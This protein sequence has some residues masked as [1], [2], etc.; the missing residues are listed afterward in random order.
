MAY[1]VSAD[2]IAPQ[3]GGFEPQRKNNFTLVIP[4]GGEILQQSLESFPIPTEENPALSIS[5]GNE[6]RKV[7]APAEYA[8]L[9]LVVKDFIDS[10]VMKQIMTWRRKVY[11]PNTGKIG[12]ARDYK[13]QGEVIMFGPDGNRARKWKL[14]GI[15]PSKVDPGGGNMSANENNMISVTFQVDK[16][17]EQ[18]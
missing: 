15:W 5:F 12:Y 2:H 1:R 18:F 7:A 11:D 8:E 6:K 3:G 10:P 4:Y 16:A 17:I 9:Q 14:M 13:Q